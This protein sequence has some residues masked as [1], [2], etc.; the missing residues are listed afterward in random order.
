MFGSSKPVVFE[1]YGRRKTRR[2]LPRW[3]VLL[4]TGAVLGVGGV[5]LVQERHLPPRLSASESTQL[6]RAFDEADSERQ[7]LKLELVDTSKRLETTLAE[8]K[9]LGDELRD[10][11]ETV[12]HLRDDV[13]TLVESL[14]PDPRGGAISVRAARFSS[15][16]QKLDYDVVLSRERATGNKPLSG[17]MKFVVAG[18]SGRGSETTFSSEPIAISVGAYESLRGSVTLPDGF[19]PRQTT[20]SLL[21]RVDGKQLGMRVIFVK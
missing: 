7:R 8:N 20:I 10:S 11:R 17:V 18:D 4:L 16:G 15:K 2:V 1:P 9:K 14:P 3:L 12:E 13:G 19:K 21:D 6:R 5:I